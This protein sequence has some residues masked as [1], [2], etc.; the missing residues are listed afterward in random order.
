[1]TTRLEKRF[2]EGTSV[3]QTYVRIG[4]AVPGATTWVTHINLTNRTA[5]TIKVRLYIADTSWSTGEPTGG[6]L[7]TAI[8]YDLPLLPGGDQQILGVVL[9]T[10][11]Q[12]IARSDTAT[13]L[14]IALSGVE[15]V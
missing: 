1:M 15:V 10:T 4:P 9:L 12:F 7:K 3:G 6:T 13:S 14:D 8:C 11:E 5:G 2:G